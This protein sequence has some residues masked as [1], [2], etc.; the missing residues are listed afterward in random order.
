MAVQAVLDQLAIPYSSIRLGSVTLDGELSPAQ[1]RKVGEG[2]KV[3]QLE[4]V[5]NKNQILIE[6]IKAEITELLHSPEPMSFKLS[7]H[8]SE[9]LDYN[10]TYLANT[11]AAIEGITLERYFIVQRVERVKEM[12]VYEDY[13]LTEI[14]DLLRYSSVSH[15]CLQFKKVTGIT[16]AEFRKLC[17]SDDFL[18]R[19]V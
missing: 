18:W 2:L 16:P 1:K 10:Y 17:R 5:E 19:A 7:V 6:R 14:T 12:I 13:S 3:Y 11:F 9:T 8:L 15:L 4:L